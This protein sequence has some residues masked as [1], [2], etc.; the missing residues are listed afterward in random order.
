VVEITVVEIKDG[1]LYILGKHVDLE[2]F[3]P[4]EAIAGYSQEKMRD[5]KNHLDQL[6]PD[7]KKSLSNQDQAAIATLQHTLEKRLAA[8]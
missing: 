2:A 3:D 4:E 5:L 8:H 1:K 7:A 6:S